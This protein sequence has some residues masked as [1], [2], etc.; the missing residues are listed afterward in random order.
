MYFK[1]AYDILHKI[2]VDGEYVGDAM[3]IL[4]EENKAL[5][6]RIVYGVL[7]REVELEY[8]ISK[9]A[10]KAPKKGIGIILKIGMYS[11]AYMD[12]LPAYAVCNKLVELTKQMGKRE[13]APFINAT[14]KRFNREKIAL[15]EKKEERLSVLSSTPLWIVKKILRQY[16]EDGEKILFHEG[17]KDSHIRFNLSCF[18]KGEL[19]KILKAKNISF[20]ESE[21]GFYVKDISSLT[22]LFDK[23]KITYQSPCS[24][25][26]GELCAEGKGKILDVCAAPGGKSVYMSE[27]TG[28]EVTACDIHEHRVGLIKSY[29]KRMGAK[30]KA[31]KNDAR[32][33]NPAFENAF[34]AVM[35]DVPCSGIGVR[36]SKPDTLLNRKESDIPELCAMQEEIIAVSSRYVKSGG[37]L[38]YSTCTVFREENERVVERFLSAHSDFVLDK[39]IKMIPGVNAS[40]GFYA[41][42][43]KKL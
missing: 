16:K 10:R 41:V 11:L 7:E 15:P 25:I 36:Y 31:V 1:K 13:V 22:E 14:L 23:G 6:T 40:E 27:L 17:E 29:A 26:I 8:Y 35:C 18:S 20:K 33:F 2:Y 28:G 3:R 30:V 5:V 9:L 32:V 21:K 39:E 43:L 42:R 19:E 24:M 12:S 37:R 34:D 4:E 38:V